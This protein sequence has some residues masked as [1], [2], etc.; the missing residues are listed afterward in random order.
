MSIAID[1]TD[2]TGERSEPRIAE[3]LEDV[4]LIWQG[5]KRIKLNGVDRTIVSFLLQA[6]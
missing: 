4:V 6:T 3:V 2:V 5:W 1:L